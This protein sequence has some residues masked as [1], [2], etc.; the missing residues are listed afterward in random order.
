[1]RE[2]EASETA[3][4]TAYMR[5]FH[6]MYESPKIFDDF[7]AYDMIPEEKRPLIQQYVTLKNRQLESISSEHGPD[8]VNVFSP[9]TQTPNALSR[10]R[11][12][13]DLLERSIKH[14]VKQYVILGAGLDTFAFRRPDLVE[15]L[16]IYEID[17]PATQQYKQ[18]RIAE[19]GWEHPTS[20][21]FIPIDFTNED[22]KTVL[23]SSDSFDRHVRSFFSWL[24]VTYYLTRDDVFATLRSIADIAPAGSRIVFDYSSIDAFIPEKSSPRMKEK[25][26]FFR[27]IGEPMITGFDPHT[28]ADDI[29]SLGLNLQEN[30]RLLDVKERYFQGH[31][32]D[33]Y[34]QEYEYIAYADIS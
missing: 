27:S 32:D 17:H 34:A 4:M 16:D 19:M 33:L 20:L 9:L 22:L 13:E 6:S 14:G 23:S 1:M 11:Y 28:L 3:M 26:E 31:T 30:L 21:H 8:Q 10:A 18:Q 25:L 5:A 7:L 24:G 29:A 12:T 2:R 15:Q